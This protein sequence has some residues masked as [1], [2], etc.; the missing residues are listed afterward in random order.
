MFLATRPRGCCW[1]WLDETFVKIFFSYT[2]TYWRTIRLH[3][4]WMY[5]NECIIFH[6]Y[7]FVFLKACIFFVSLFWWW[8]IWTWW[9]KYSSRNSQNSMTERYLYCYLD[10]LDWIILHFKL[11][12]V[13][14]IKLY[15][16]MW[17]LRALWLV[18]A[19]DLLKRV[20]ARLFKR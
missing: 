20:Q 3:L 17:M 2:Q 18:V 4:F 13:F 7:F 15:T 14:S 16:M 8:V 10:Y 11:Y 19:H 12:L 5:G 9:R 1:C 6:N